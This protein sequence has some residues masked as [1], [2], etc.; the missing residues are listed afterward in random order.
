MPVTFTYLLCISTFFQNALQLYNFKLKPK[1]SQECNSCK[2]K[3]FD[4]ITMIFCI[5]YKSICYPVNLGYP[6]LGEAVL[7]YL[8]QGKTKTG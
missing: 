1:D 2:L 4:T 5:V 6:I 8:T 3:D 7:G